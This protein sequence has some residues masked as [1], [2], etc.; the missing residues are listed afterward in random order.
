MLMCYNMGDVGSASETN[1][2]LRPSIARTYLAKMNAYPLPLDVALPLF[3]WGVEE[4]FGKPV[5]ILDQVELPDLQDT[6]HFS[7]VSP[8][9]FRATQSQ[10][11]HGTYLYRDAVIR[12]EHASPDSLRALME[13]LSPHLEAMEGKHEIALYHLHPGIDA[14]C[15]EAIQSSPLITTLVPRGVPAGASQA[16]LGAWKRKPQMGSPD[17]E[18]GLE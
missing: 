10:Y 3:G 12:Y 1:S 15:W 13:V 11:L 5:R 9:R 8:G 6:A 4:R 18:E 7:P 14:A 17:S 16:R 2:I